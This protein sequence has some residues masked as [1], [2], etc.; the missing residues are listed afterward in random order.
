MKKYLFLLT[1]FS[2]IVFGCNKSN[3]NE[4]ESPGIEGNYTGRFERNGTT[5]NVTLQLQN[6]EFNGTSDSVYFPAI[7]NGNYQIAADTI[8]FENLSAWPANIDNSL[9]LSGNWHY[10]FNTGTLTMSKDG[11]R[12]V[13]IHQ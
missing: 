10:T 2:L 8:S 9:I 5:S 12:Y 1:V 13:L 11:D 7:G 3:N 6:N 4:P